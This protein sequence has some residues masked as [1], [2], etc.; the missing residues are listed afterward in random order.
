VRW[1]KH[2]N[3]LFLDECDVHPDSGQPHDDECRI[4]HGLEQHFLQNEI[5][6]IAYQPPLIL[7]PFVQRR[8]AEDRDPL[9][10]GG[11][12]GEVRGGEK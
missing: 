2:T 1:G 10:L 8:S 4:D 6:G 9:S 7:R 5:V 3:R 11:G 12:E